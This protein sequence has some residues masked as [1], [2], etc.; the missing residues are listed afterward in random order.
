MKDVCPERGSQQFKKNGHIHTGKQN[1]QCK[2][3]NRQFVVHATHRVIDEEQRML[4]ERLLCEKISLRGICRAPRVSI[5]RLID[6]MVARF[7]AAPAH[8][9]VRPVAASRSILIGCLAVEV[10]EL[11]GIVQ[12]KA[13][14][15]GCGSP[16]TRRRVKSLPSTSGIADVIA[17][18]NCWL[19]FRQCIMS[20]QPSILINTLPRPA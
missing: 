19:T 5:R 13:T 8:L 20:R 2:D 12:K 3:C 15:T 1:H 18:N 17:L 10:D 16:W 4:V 14:H 11:W 6:F 9:H 7:A